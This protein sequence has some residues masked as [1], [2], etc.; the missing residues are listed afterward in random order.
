[1]WF[2]NRI[3]STLS[4]GGLAVAGILAAGSGLAAAGN[5]VPLPRT[6]QTII[7]TPSP[8]A[9][10]VA[11]EM[12]E[13]VKSKIREQ[14]I[15]A[16]R[17]DSLVWNGALDGQKLAQEMREEMASQMRGEMLAGLQTALGESQ[18]HFEPGPIKGE[19]SS[20]STTERRVAARTPTGAHP[21]PTPLP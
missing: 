5:S 19:A 18:P 9:S 14:M 6:L 20:P 10:V 4:L 3:L 15:T 8:E 21:S 17:P 16:L 1:M 7:W 2:S 12:R 11:E 13:T